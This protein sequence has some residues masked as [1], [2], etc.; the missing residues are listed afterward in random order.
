VG[1]LVLVGVLVSVGV[2][3]GVVVFVSVG[4]VL[5]VVVFVS[6]GVVLG[7]GLSGEP[8]LGIPGEASVL[9]CHVLPSGTRAKVFAGC[10]P[11]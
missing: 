3:V 1:V 5:G 2:A 11:V 10:A 6:V 8:S 4:V 7:V 9:L